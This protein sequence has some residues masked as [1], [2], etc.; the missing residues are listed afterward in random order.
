VVRNCT[1]VLYR[2]MKFFSWFLT[3]DSHKYARAGSAEDTNLRGAL[4]RQWNNL[5][6]LPVDSGF[7]TRKNFTENCPQFGHPPPRDFAISDRSRKSLK[8]SDSKERQIIGQPWTPTS[9]SGPA[10]VI[11]RRLQKMSVPVFKCI[12][13]YQ[14]SH[15]R[16]MGRPGE[17][18]CS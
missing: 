9:L 11:S 4:R 8:N 15:S 14:K 18:G 13:L 6:M 10:L 5:L 12:Y 3:C 16:V 2:F 17:L 1:R 7:H